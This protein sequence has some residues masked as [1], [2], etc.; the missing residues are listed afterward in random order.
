MPIAMLTMTYGGSGLIWARCDQNWRMLR[1]VWVREMLSKVSLDRLYALRHR[2][3][4]SS[5]K[6]ATWLPLPWPRRRPPLAARGIAH[7]TR[8]GILYSRRST[9]SGYFTTGAC[10]KMEEKCDSTSPIRH[11]W[12]RWRRLPGVHPR[13]T[14]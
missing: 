12:I 5:L 11:V 6:S 7:S 9:F 4:G 3:V 13:P 8:G 1:K 2:D 10:H 14:I